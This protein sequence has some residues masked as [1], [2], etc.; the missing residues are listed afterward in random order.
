[1]QTLDNAVPTIEDAVKTQAFKQWWKDTVFMLASLT[2]FASADPHLSFAASSTLVLATSR[3][4]TKREMLFPG[5]QV[6]L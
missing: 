3:N 2:A 5:F 6:H 4:S 1:M